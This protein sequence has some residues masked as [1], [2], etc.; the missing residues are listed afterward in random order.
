MIGPFA[1][2]EMPRFFD[3]AFSLAKGEIYGVIKSPYGYHIIMLEERY[4]KTEET[5]EQA[6]ASINAILTENKRKEEYKK[7]LET[8]INAIPVK[9]P[10]SKI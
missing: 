7:W 8:A 3:L 9:T 4:S 2:G 1:Q 6:R 10:G 5:L